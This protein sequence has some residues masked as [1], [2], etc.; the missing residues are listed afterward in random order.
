MHFLSDFNYIVGLKWCLVLF[1]LPL[2]HDAGPRASSSLCLSIAILYINSRICVVSV[3]LCVY[4]VWMYGCAVRVQYC[5]HT[6][7]SY[8]DM[9]LL[10]MF[11][12][13][14]M[15]S[16]RVWACVML[17]RICKEYFCFAQCVYYIVYILIRCLTLYKILSWNY[18]Q[19]ER[20]RESEPEA[21][22]GFWYSVYNIS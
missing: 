8:M 4:C 3:C 6:H 7:F 19:R 13:K 18:T 20:E 10:I 15:L 5:I 16:F 17:H 22:D 14:Y 1:K 9:L 12:I 11:I 2:T 21:S